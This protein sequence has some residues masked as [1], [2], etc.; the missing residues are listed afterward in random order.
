LI[1]L[2]QSRL[3]QTSTSQLLAMRLCFAESQLFLS[4]GGHS[5]NTALNPSLYAFPHFPTITCAL[6]RYSPY[7]VLQ[8]CGIIFCGCPGYVTGC[9]CAAPE[10]LSVLKSTNSAIAA[11]KSTKISITAAIPL[12]ISG[13]ILF[14]FKYFLG[15]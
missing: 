4:T 5:V 14:V 9:I 3:Q 8:H 10:G 6:G 2:N 11:I 15:R 1:F 13:V 7:P 12:F